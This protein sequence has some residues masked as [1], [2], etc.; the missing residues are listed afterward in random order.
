MKEKEVK[1]GN[2]IAAKA[3][4]GTLIIVVLSI[5]I[6]FMADKAISFRDINTKQEFRELV[7]N[8]MMFV[9]II[10]LSML[11]LSIYLIFIYLKDYLELKSKFTLGILLAVVSFM[12]FAITSNPTLH[13]F[14]G[15]YGKTGVFMLIPYIFATISLAILAWISSK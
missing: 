2:N 9:N 15:I 14:F 7:E 10:T 13:Q 3:A 6:L 8:Y 5:A 1:K 11:L 4:A 12:L